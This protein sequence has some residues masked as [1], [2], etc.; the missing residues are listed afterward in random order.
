MNPRLPPVIILLKG[1]THRLPTV[2]VWRA[3]LTANRSKAAARN[4]AAI[5]PKRRR[6]R[7]PTARA[8][9]NPPPPQRPIPEAQNKPQGN[10]SLRE[11][12]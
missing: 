5:T 11:P 7:D 2:S 8:D 9:E 4:P 3:Q 1:E 12:L 6:R 10:R